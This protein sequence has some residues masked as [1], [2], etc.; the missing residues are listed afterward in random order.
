MSSKRLLF[1]SAIVAAISVNAAAQGRCCAADPIAPCTGSG[2]EQGYAIDYSGSLLMQA[3]D[4][5]TAPYYLSSRRDGTL[6]VSPYVTAARIGAHRDRDDSRRF[7]YSFGADLVAGYLSGVEYGRWLTDGDKWGKHDLR[8]SPVHLQQLYGSVKW[9][10]LLLQAGLW[11]N[12]FS[13][14]PALGS[15]DLVYSD[16]ARPVPQVRLGFVRFQDVP[17][18]RGWLQVMAD[19]AYGKFTDSRWLEKQF[20]YYSDFVTTGTLMHHKRL[21]FR[22]ADRQPLAFTVGLQHAAQFGGTRRIYLDGK[23]IEEHKMKGGLKQFLK[24]LVPSRGEGSEYY[25]GN[26]LGSWDASL[27]WRLPQGHCLTAYFQWPWEDGSGIGK[28]NG[29]DGV[30]GLS[31]SAATPQ[32]IDR[33]TVEYID[34]TNQSGPMHWAPGDFP[35]TG[36]PGEATG[37]DDYYNNFTYDGWA[38]YGMSMGSPFVKSPAYNLDGYPAFLDNRLRGYHIGIS[39]TPAAGWNYELLF[40]Q[41]TSWGTPKIP[42][43]HRRHDTSWSAAASWTPRAVPQLAVTAQLAGTHGSLYGNSFGARV[44]LTYSGTFTFKKKHNGK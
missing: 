36:I 42:A 12:T 5:K 24:V 2:T 33:A 18:T 14:F 28:L 27:R 19:V 13:I 34:L 41:R 40:S 6:W 11:E 9:R 17:L 32:W 22:V 43:P 23:M 25:D 38:N 8:P 3:S 44:S 31:Y 21:Y 15:G 7:A 26:S 39:G 30:W 20:N 29:W 35:G 10:S 16:N 1:A 37:A 4:G